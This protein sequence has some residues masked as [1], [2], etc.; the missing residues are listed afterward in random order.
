[1]EILDYIKGK[2]YSPQMAGN[3]YKLKCILPGHEHDKDPSFIIYPHT[4]TFNCFGCDTGGKLPFL[5]R[6]LGDTIPLEFFEEP[7]VELSNIRF[8]GKIPLNKRIA[9]G[10]NQIR[11][12][13]KWYTNSERLDMRLKLIVGLANEDTTF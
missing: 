8:D 13:R 1:M 6:L 10:I 7:P 3:I 11:R 2:G 9:N 5:M 12:L 4:N